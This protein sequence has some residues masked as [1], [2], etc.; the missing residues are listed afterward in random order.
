MRLQEDTGVSIGVVGQQPKRHRFSYNF[1][2]IYL[3]GSGDG[4][5]FVGLRA[6]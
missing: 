4:A 2:M 5:S 6:G 3:K 1:I